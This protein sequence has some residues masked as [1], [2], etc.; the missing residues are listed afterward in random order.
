M[1]VDKFPTHP[2]FTK[3]VDEELNFDAAQWKNVIYL[4]I[5]IDWESLDIV[6]QQ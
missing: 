1:N 4:C 6:F 3:E 5:I 2:K